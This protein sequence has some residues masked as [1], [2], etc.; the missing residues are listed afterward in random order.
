MI[1]LARANGPPSGRVRAVT[2]SRLS[3]LDPRTYSPRM[4]RPSIAG[5]SR[6]GVVAARAAA[7]ALLGVV[8][9]TGCAG[10]V[11]RPVGAEGAGAGARHEPPERAPR[12]A[13]PRSEEAPPQEEPESPAGV[14]HRVMAGQTLWRIAKVYGVDLD[15]ILRVNGIDDP[16]RIDVGQRVF[17]PGA[18]RMLDVPPYPAPLPDVAVPAPPEPEIEERGA[19]DFQWPVGGGEILS[20]FGAR[21][22]THRHAGLDIRGRPGQEVVAAQ[23]GVVTFSGSTRTGYGKLVIIDHGG[24]FESLY[25]HNSENLVAAGDEVAQGQTIAR[26]GRTGN[27]TTAHTHFEIRRG[28]VPIDPLPYFLSVAEVRP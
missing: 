10:R 22:R 9:L 13:V 7:L 5:P 4:R 2:G 15:E 11:Q 23:G 14:F 6:R 16:E 1:A 19:G 20:R 12:D 8:E 28:G 21:R 3:G 27:A 18:G 25:A 26:V 17:V 24:G